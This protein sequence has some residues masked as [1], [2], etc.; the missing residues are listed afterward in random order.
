LDAYISLVDTLGQDPHVKIA[1]VSA[2][3]DDEVTRLI[4]ELS[5]SGPVDPIERKLHQLVE[6]QAAKTP[7]TVAV[8][9]EDQY[10]TYSQLNSKA[11]RLARMLSQQGVGPD[12]IVAICFE[13]GIPQI[14][15]ILSI[16]KACGAF[17]PLDPDNPTLRKEMLIVDTNAKILLSTYSQRRDF[18]R[19][20]ASKVIVSTVISFYS[21]LSNH[22]P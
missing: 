4:K 11:Y 5:T 3:S 18:D 13:R 14:L 1:D 16:L 9:Y 15:A 7:T 22:L 6:A 10:L 17:L 12:S 8:E 21:T 2:V 20:L 19:A